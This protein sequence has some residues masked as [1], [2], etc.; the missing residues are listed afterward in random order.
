MQAIYARKSAVR[1]NVCMSL[2][3]EYSFEK[4]SIAVD[5]LAASADN[6]KTR[7]SRAADNIGRVRERDVPEELREQFRGIY[8]RITSGVPYNR[9]GT[10]QATINQITDE[11][12]VQIAS[13]IVSFNESLLYWRIKHERSTLR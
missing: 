1:Y 7:L 6:I 12:A 4:F 10:L 5:D 11:E 3:F 8:E 13:D 9:E 2:E